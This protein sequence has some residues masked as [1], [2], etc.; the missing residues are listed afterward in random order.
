MAPATC[1]PSSVPFENHVGAFAAGR[2][3]DA[4][5]Q[6][7]VA[8]DD[9]DVFPLV[10]PRRASQQGEGRR[11]D[12]EDLLL[13]AEQEQPLLHVGGDRFDRVALGAQPL[14]LLADQAVL[15]AQLPVE[16]LELLI[17]A[18]AVGVFEVLRQRLHR[19]HQPPGQAGGQQ[20]AQQQGDE[21][22]ARH[23]RDHPREDRAD[24]AGLLGDAQDAAVGQGG[25]VVAGVEPHR[26]G[27]ADVLAAAYAERLPHLGAVEMVL[28]ARAVVVR[29]EEHPALRGDEGDAEA[30]EPD[31]QAG[32]VVQPLLPRV[33]DRPGD[34]LVFVAQLLLHLPHEQSVGRPEGQRRREQ[35]HADRRGAQAP[36]YVPFH[37]GLLLAPRAYSPIL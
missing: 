1:P 2:A 7:G 16:G 22:D 24:A 34:Q 3:L 6:L 32:E 21:H 30:V 29:V 23:E 35:R 4:R 37:L 18:Q 25:R 17:A 33:G 20:H 27:A 15:F 5:A 14:H 9:E 26:L 11:V 31:V 36:I 13:P 10:F 19:P 8:G 12:R 28:H